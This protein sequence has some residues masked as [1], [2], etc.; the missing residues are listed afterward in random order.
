MYLLYLWRIF[1]LS[2]HTLFLSPF[3]R[4]TIPSVLSPALYTLSCSCNV[5]SLHCVILPVFSSVFSHVV[6]LYFPPSSVCSEDVHTSL[7]IPLLGGSLMHEGAPTSAPRGTPLLTSHRSPICIH[8]SPLSNLSNL[9]YW[10]IL[11]CSQLRIS[12]SMPDL[13]TLSLLCRIVWREKKKK[14]CGSPSQLC[15][16]LQPCQLSSSPPLQGVNHICWGW[17]TLHKWILLAALA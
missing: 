13:L 5:S 11:F 3:C 15:L 8:L 2:P 7:S 4:K 16:L 14:P 10:A 6:S 9:G 17:P 1:L 12:L